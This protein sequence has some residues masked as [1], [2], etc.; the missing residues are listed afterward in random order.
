MIHN[1]PLGLRVHGEV[2]PS[3]EL[4]NALHD[5]STAQRRARDRMFQNWTDDHDVPDLVYGRP[6]HASACFDK[7]ADD[8][9]ADMATFRFRHNA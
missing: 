5:I 1:K 2:P 4:A 6:V 3:K 7:F 8:F 9:V